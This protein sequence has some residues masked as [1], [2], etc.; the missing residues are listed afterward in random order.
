MSH[1]VRLA[2]IVFSTSLIL[3]PVALG[4]PAHAAAGAGAPAGQWVASA[5]IRVSDV[6][7]TGVQ[8]D[9]VVRSN[10]PKGMPLNG[11]YRCLA[12]QADGS[13]HL[14]IIRYGKSGSSG[15]GYLHALV[16]HNLDLGPMEGVIANSQNGIRQSNG[17]YL[18]GAFH[19]APKG[20]VDQ[21]VNV[22]EER[23]EAANKDGHELGVVT[24]YCQGPG[25]SYE[26]KCP[27]WVNET[28]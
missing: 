20:Q 11:P 13:G 26:A 16:D 6:L 1:R 14:V 21:Y 8:P 27:E 25:H 28:L 15:F 18:Y 7:I 24:A 17:R 3:L 2:G 23:G 9:G 10:C 12:A 22:F 19:V 5:P 4:S